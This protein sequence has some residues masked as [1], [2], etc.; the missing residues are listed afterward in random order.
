M[1]FICSFD[2]LTQAPPFVGIHHQ[3]EIITDGLT[4]D[5]RSFYIFINR[6]TADFYFQRFVSHF[7]IFFNFCDHIFFGSAFAII[8]P[9]HVAIYR[10]IATT[11]EFIEWQACCFGHDIP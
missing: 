10:I 8:T 7:H 11:E 1:E 5:T 6:D 4:D 2:R 3:T 9:C